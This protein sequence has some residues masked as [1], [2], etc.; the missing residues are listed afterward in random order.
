[1]ELTAAS[2]A[3]PALRGSNERDLA[4]FI[5]TTAVLKSLIYAK[6][7]ARQSVVNIGK[8]GMCFFAQLLVRYKALVAPEVFTREEPRSHSKSCPPRH[9]LRICRCVLISRTQK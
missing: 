1:M 5:A 4:T 3:I 6:R 9:S 7:G 2:V 8:H